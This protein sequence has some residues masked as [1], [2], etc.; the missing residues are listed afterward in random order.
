MRRR[1]AESIDPIAL[2]RRVDGNSIRAAKR[3][4]RIENLVEFAV[5]KHLLIDLS[6]ERD[7]DYPWEIGE[8]LRQPSFT[9]YFRSPGTSV[10]HSIVFA[11]YSPKVCILRRFQI[12]ESTFEFSA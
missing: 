10:A 4:C 9:A 12:L 3:E 1:S 2:A 6:R 11:I 7:R 8:V 5:S